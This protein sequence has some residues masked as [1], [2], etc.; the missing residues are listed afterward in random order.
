MN[1]DEKA[2]R[3][4]VETW[5][6][7]TTAGDLS[8]VLG[9]MSDDVVFLAP[10]V[11]PMR[12][13]GFAAVSRDIQGHMRIDGSFEIQEIRVFGDWAY[14]WNQ[15]VVTMTPAEGGGTIERSGPALSILSRGP[16]AKWVIF[17]DANMVAPA[18]PS[19]G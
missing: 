13:D 5:F 11:A 3:S 4:L 10:G 15:I 18:Q 6:R 2:I 17:R 19:A 7:A 16:D 1:P 8:T 14:C 9:L 12:K